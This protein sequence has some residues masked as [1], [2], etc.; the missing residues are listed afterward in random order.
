MPEPLSWICSSLRP[1]CF[2]TT[3]ILVDLASKLQ[4]THKQLSSMTQQHFLEC[5]SNKYHECITKS[6]V[7]LQ[8]QQMLGYLNIHLPLS[9]KTRKW[10][11]AS[12]LF[13]I[14]SLM[15]FAGLWIT[16]PAAIL[17]T[18]VSSSFLITWA[19]SITVAVSWI[20][21]MIPMLQYSVVVFTVVSTIANSKRHQAWDNSNT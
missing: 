17:F 20:E 19:S 13:S 4:Q 6:S 15:A 12:C 2:T 3:W 7:A 10:S 8:I 1:P 14:I 9:A 18:T 16:S 11:T 5:S 21:I